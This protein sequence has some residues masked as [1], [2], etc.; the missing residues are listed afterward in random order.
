MKEHVTQCNSVAHWAIKTIKN[1]SEEEEISAVIRAQYLLV[2]TLIV[3]LGF[4]EDK[5]I[6]EYNQTFQIL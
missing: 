2:D 1:S 5:K 3:G 4:V 6:V